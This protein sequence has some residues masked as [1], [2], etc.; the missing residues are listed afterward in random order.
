M[1]N[2]VNENGERST[3][4]LSMLFAVPLHTSRKDFVLKHIIRI[5]Y[6]TRLSFLLENFM[7]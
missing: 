2:C 4:Y 6:F 5:D 1:R 7:S 3:A